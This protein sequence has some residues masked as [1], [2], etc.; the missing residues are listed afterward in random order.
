[1]NFDGNTKVGNADSEKLIG[2]TIRE[3]LTTSSS[4]KKSQK[5]A[6]TPRPSPDQRRQW[7]LKNVDNQ[8]VEIYNVQTPSMHTPN[9]N[10]KSIA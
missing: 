8:R 3:Q 5:I 6:P 1:M 4:I 7:K 10:K 9:P 2:E